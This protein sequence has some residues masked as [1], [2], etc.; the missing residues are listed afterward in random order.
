MDTILLVALLAALLTMGVVGQTISWWL[1]HLLR[2]RHP[3]LYESLG[4]P[5]V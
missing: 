5:T 1:L 2:V 4:S 3:S